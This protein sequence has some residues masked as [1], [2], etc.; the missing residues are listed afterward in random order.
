MA[1]EFATPERITF[2]LRHTSGILCAPMIPE[3]AQRLELPPMVA[4]G[5][6]PNGTAFTVTVDHVNT[7][8]VSLY[9]LWNHHDIC[10]VQD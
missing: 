10:L 1:A 4:K 8:T 3:Y 2:A 5:N 6:D 7:T 9:S